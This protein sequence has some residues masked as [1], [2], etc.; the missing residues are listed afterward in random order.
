MP[1]PLTLSREYRIYLAL[2]RKAY[3]QLKSGSEELVT[4]K[5]SS[6]NTALS[7][8]QGLYRAIRPYRYEEQ[9]DAELKAASEALVVAVPKTA[10]GPTT[11]QFKPRMTLSELEAELANFGLDEADLLLPDEKAVAKSLESLITSDN[12]TKPSINSTPFY[13]RN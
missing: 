1:S 8:R 3:Q 10:A 2:W 6:F 11:V 7:M 12:A 5:A 4:L 13:T 9:F